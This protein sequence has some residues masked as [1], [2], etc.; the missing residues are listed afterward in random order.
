[1]NLE[2]MYSLYCFDNTLKKLLNRETEKFSLELYEREID[3]KDKL[4]KVRSGWYFKVS[5]KEKEDIWI[6]AGVYYNYEK[7]LVCVEVNNHG[8]WG[9]PFFHKLKNYTH[10]GTYAS[11]PYQERDGS[12]YYFEA[13]D[14]FNEEFDNAKNT[15]IQKNTL[16]KFIDEIVEV[17]V[18]N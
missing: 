7:A 9:K 3:T 16:C 10:N 11:S 15:D 2:N 18:N 14:I 8:G 13:S 4:T 6:W 12:P 17:Y 5:A 1:M